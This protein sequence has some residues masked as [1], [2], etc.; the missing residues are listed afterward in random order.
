MST[1]SAPGLRSGYSVGSPTRTCAATGR[2]LETGESYVAA[3]VLGGSGGDEFRRMDFSLASW[4]AGSRP[5]SES[6]RP[7]PVF[8]SWRAVVPEPGARR[9]M[10]IDDESLLDLFEQSGGEPAGSAP[11]ADDRRAFRFM[12]ALILLRKKLLVCERTDADGTMHV[13][14]RG[15][16]KAAEGGVLATVEDP[17]LSEES[18][19]GVVSQ[20][21][22][23]LD[24]ESA[25]TGGAAA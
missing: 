24:G 9:R 10:L 18:I 13:R 23:V 5:T 8:G 12:L 6:G 22:A 7:L 1:L 15:S 11:G 21:S 19:A 16:P 17:G 20:L 2:A 4:Q 3:L 25:G 14:P